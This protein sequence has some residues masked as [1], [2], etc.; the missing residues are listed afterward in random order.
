MQRIMEKLVQETQNLHGDHTRAQVEA[1]K[2]SMKPRTYRRSVREEDAIDE[3]VNPF[4]NPL[5]QD[6]PKSGGLDE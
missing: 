2:V 4:H 6:K 5:I 3:Q 1:P